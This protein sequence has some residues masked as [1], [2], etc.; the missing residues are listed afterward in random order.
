MEE[1]TCSK[2]LYLL[3]MRLTGGAWRLPDI[4]IPELLACLGK[5][6][7]ELATVNIAKKGDEKVVRQKKQPEELNFLS[8]QVSNVIIKVCA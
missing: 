1:K 3:G 2:I 6:G 7:G 8:A 5:V 4:I